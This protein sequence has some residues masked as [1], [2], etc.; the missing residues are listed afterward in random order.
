[1]DLAPFCLAF[2]AVFGMM[3]D[4]L[5]QERQLGATIHAPF[6]ELESVDMPFE[7]PIPLGQCQAG[8]HSRFILLNALGK[9]LQFG[10]VAR[11]YL[12]EP[13]V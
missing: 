5:A 3:Q 8:K 1:V 12:A 7:R 11:I 13:S 4:A 6:N 10:Q 9:R 2:F